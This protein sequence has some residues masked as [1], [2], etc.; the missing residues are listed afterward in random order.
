MLGLAITAT[1]T[2]IVAWVARDYDDEFADM[3]MVVALGL[4]AAVVVLLLVAA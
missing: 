3:L 1:V 4:W 2:S